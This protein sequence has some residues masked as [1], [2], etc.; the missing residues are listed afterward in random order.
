MA[1]AKLGMI[2][3]QISPFLQHARLLEIIEILIS[4]IVYQQVVGKVMIIIFI[5]S[6]L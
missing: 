1:L 6:S 2:H 3:N 4:I 5:C